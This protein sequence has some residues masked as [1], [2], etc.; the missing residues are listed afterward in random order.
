MLIYQEFLVINEEMA[1]FDPTDKLR[2][3]VHEIVIKLK[4]NTELK[5]D[6]LSKILKNEYKVDIS[7]EILKEIFTA[8]DKHDGDFSF[9]KKDDKNWMEAWPYAGYIKKKSRDKQNFG[10]HRKKDAPVYTIYG[11][12]YSAGEK[13][14][15]GRW[16]KTNK[17]DDTVYPYGGHEYYGD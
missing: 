16:V 12:S 1:S 15:N 17:N 11:S 10:K 6:E 4:A 2:W 5:F 14:I 13:W 3:A 9:F 7:T 8:W